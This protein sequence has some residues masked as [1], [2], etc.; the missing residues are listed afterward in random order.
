M[1]TAKIDA[2]Q[3]VS[4]FIKSIGHDNFQKVK[5]LLEQI[6]NTGTLEY[7]VNKAITSEGL[8]LI[9]LASKVNNIEI[10]RL[11][12]KYNGNIN[13]HGGYIWKNCIARIALCNNKQQFRC[14]LQH[15]K[16]I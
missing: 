9:V 14:G 16:V 8:P 13:N 4:T 11:M 2:T 12:L 7:I 3:L 5:R 10:V 1:S 15:F 6:A